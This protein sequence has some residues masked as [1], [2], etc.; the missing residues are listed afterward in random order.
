MNEIHTA[1][2][3]HCEESVPSSVFALFSMPGTTPCEVMHRE[4]LD[5]IASRNSSMIN[6]S[7]RW[8]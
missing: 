5:V 6:K 3:K 1:C 8:Y 4:W 2:G 7:Y